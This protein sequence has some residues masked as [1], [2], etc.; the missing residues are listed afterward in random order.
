MANRKITTVAGGGRIGMTSLSKADDYVASGRAVWEHSDARH[1]GVRLYR[2]RFIDLDHRNTAADASAN[3]KMAKRGFMPA[4]DMTVADVR[5]MR[6]VP[7]M[8]P[9]K[10]LYKIP[11]VKA[12]KPEP[13]VVLKVAGQRPDLYR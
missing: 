8:T 7:I 11:S 10:M 1:G 2:I 9:E 6:G 12:R 5:G 13:C 4:S 3:S